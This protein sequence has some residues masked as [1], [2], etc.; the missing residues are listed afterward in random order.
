MPQVRK[1]SG[2]SKRIEVDGYFILPDAASISESRARLCA[3]DLRLLEQEEAFLIA[4]KA[5]EQLKGRWFW[6]SGEGGTE[7]EGIY[8]FNKNGALS[9]GE[10]ASAENTVRIFPGKGPLAI[11]I[12]TDE[13]THRMEA[14]FLLVA[15]YSP[16]SIAPLC[17]GISSD[18]L[19]GLARRL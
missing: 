13:G 3:S 8:R 11:F 10:G 18:G 5:K 12:L 9:R 19:K 7:K 14:R 16:G 4:V 17:V 2:Q 15:D 6:I 1:A